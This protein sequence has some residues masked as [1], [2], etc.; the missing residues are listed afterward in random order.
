MNN[1]GL[2]S[3][4]EL[5]YLA[6]GW[7]NIS[8]KTHKDILAFCKDRGMDI[9]KLTVSQEEWED[10]GQRIKVV[11]DKEAITIIKQDRA[12][13]ADIRADIAILIMILVLFIG[14]SIDVLKNG[15]EDYNV[16]LAILF[17]SLLLFMAWVSYKKIGRQKADNEML[18]EVV[19]SDQTI[20]F[21][22]SKKV[23]FS[24]ALK[25]IELYWTEGWEAGDLPDVTLDL[26]LDKGDIIR[27]DEGGG[28]KEL[29]LLSDKLQDYTKS[30]MSLQEGKPPS[31]INQRL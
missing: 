19:I 31:S 14:V 8:E 20:A 26:V 5:R 13:K 21:K 30:Q 10:S 3:K 6:K 16:I 12:K 23:V 18:K 22:L 15:F 25:S 29:F 1:Y 17:F 7:A 28:Y 27:I 2:F 11:E 4:Y 9:H 24:G